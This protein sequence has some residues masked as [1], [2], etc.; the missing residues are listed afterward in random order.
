MNLKKIYD[1]VIQVNEV[2]ASRKFI[3]NVFMD[4]CSAG[5]ICGVCLRVCQQQFNNFPDRSRNISAHTMLAYIAMFS[6]LAFVLLMFR[7]K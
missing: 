5:Y 6:P 1:N 2:D 3:A 7:A 4:V